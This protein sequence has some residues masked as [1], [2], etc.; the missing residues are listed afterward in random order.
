VWSAP[1]ASVMQL[2]CRTGP[3]MAFQATNRTVVASD[4]KMVLRDVAWQSVPPLR[5]TLPCLYRE[6]PS[7]IMFA[8]KTQQP[9]V[10]SQADS[11]LKYS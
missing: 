10:F 7:A 6:S 1:G 4:V 5:R 11:L 3:C 9:N 2:M 8:K